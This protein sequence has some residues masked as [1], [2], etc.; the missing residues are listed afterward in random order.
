MPPE[1]D[2][3]Q[4]AQCTTDVGEAGLLMTGK[5]LLCLYARRAP[6][7]ILVIFDPRTLFSGHS[8]RRA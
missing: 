1:L 7:R 4:P 5:R 8:M 3:H 6:M 2:F